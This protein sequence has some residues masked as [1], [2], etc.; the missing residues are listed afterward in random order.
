MGSVLLLAPPWL[1]HRAAAGNFQEICGNK[2]QE[3]QP[4]GAL[5]A[6][7]MPVA[8]TPTVS[9]LARTGEG[10]SSA[11]DKGMEKGMG[12]FSKSALE[13]DGASMRCSKGWRLCLHP[14]LSLSEPLQGLCGAAPNICD[15]LP[16][17]PVGLGV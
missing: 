14:W 12:F 17:L 5:I 7:G 10:C 13:V 11:R 4:K 6:T 3:L 8:D 15:P 9:I 2:L 1:L 16:E